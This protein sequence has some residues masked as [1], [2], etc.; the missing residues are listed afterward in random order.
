MKTLRIGVVEKN[1]NPYWDRINAGWQH[2]A[3][4]LNMN[5]NIRAP[6]HENIDEQRSLIR[7]QLSSGVDAL[8]FVAS[9]PNGF[10]DLVS[11][12]L[13]A[14]IPTI[15]FDLDA[16]NS[17]R[18]YFIGM[19]SPCDAGHRAGKEMVKHIPRG[20]NVIVQTGSAVAQGAIG[21]RKGF[22]EIMAE[23]EISVI[24][25]AIDNEDNNQA[26]ESLKEALSATP[27]V[28]GLF[29]G[30]GYHAGIQAKVAQELHVSPVIIGYDLLPDTIA[31]IENGAITMSF[32]I[33]EYCFG[34]FGG[35]MLSDACRL[36]LDTA[37]KIRGM[38]TIH[39]AQN[40]NVPKPV[41]VTTDNITD[42]RNRLKAM[43]F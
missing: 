24:E 13:K 19:E 42:I 28:A 31:G 22:L 12:A 36:G 34:L 2:A 15:T 43:T 26:Y 23:H 7:E 29:G 18:S 30:Y 33:Q 10:D 6:K 32:W 38:D 25:T 40:A 5:L 41:A 11:E 14:E 4:A 39:L 20:S 37:L 35:A 17:G 1:Q 16:P 3:S 27:D 8:A 9:D 21:K